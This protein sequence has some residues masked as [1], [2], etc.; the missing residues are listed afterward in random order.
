ML[1]RPEHTCVF[2]KEARIRIQ[3]PHLRR[4][5]GHEIKSTCSADKSTARC[6][7]LTEPC[8]PPDWGCM[9]YVKVEREDCGLS[10]P[11]T[12]LSE[13]P[14]VVLTRKRSKSCTW[15][16]R[17]GH[18]AQAQFTWR[19]RSSPQARW[20]RYSR[21]TL[22]PRLWPMTICGARP[23]KAARNSWATSV[24]DAPRVWGGRNPATWLLS[25][26]HRWSTRITRHGLLA[27]Q[28]SL[29]SNHIGTILFSSHMR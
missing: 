26:W 25:P 12:K 16:P 15:S 24:A 28:S 19:G 27:P 10:R 22:P 18:V 9:L 23:S 7:S 2:G 21:A 6:T 29:V 3:H 4:T 20:R 5:N 14:D 1:G 8:R 17:V 13:S 11:T